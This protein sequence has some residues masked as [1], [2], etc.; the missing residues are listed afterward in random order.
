MVSA[1]TDWSVQ[2]EFEFEV[3]FIVQRWL[4]A[5]YSV[6]CCWRKAHLKFTAFWWTK[7]EGDKVR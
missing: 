6:A 5:H 3:L 7:R 2:C 4:F 1:N